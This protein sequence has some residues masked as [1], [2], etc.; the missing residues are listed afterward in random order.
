MDVVKS[1]YEKTE[2]HGLKDFFEELVKTGNV[3]EKTRMSFAREKGFPYEL[4]YSF[5]DTEL[6]K[7]AQDIASDDSYTNVSE[8]LSKMPD[9]IINA[10]YITDLDI[11]LYNIAN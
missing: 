10:F 8:Y 7:L 2:K 5:F 3:S 6:S 11:K 1:F 9:N 4:F